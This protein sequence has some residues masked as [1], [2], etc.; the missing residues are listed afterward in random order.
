MP[1]PFSNGGSSN[2]DSSNRV[3]RIQRNAIRSWAQLAPA[4]EVLLIGDEEGIE[5][6]ANDLG[7]RH[8]GG[9]QYNEQGTPLVS[10]AFEI[11]HEHCHSPL[12]AYCNSDVILTPD[13]VNTIER[14][15]DLKQNDPFVAFGRRID[16]PIEKEVD[17]DSDEWCDRLLEDSKRV[18]KISSQACKEYFIFTCDLY[19]DVPPFAIGRGNWDNWMIYSA[20]QNGVPVI[21]VSQ[22]LTALHQAHDYA[23][24]KSNRMNCYVSGAEAKENQ[25]LAGGRHLISGS[26]GTHRLTSTGIK[27]ETTLIVNPHFWADV[28]RF[29]RLMASLVARR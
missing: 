22:H 1:K 24:T 29:L 23:H 10:S 3:D 8:A 21:N 19:Q 4:A 28:P 16:L 6:T 14:L 17:F 18:G 5:S 25:R 12:L 20:K 7:V 15:I 13:F 9:V 11:A 2:G 26:V 27:P